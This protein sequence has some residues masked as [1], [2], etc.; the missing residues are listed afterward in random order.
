M[1]ILESGISTFFR[2][3]LGRAVERQEEIAPRLSPTWLKI[4]SG[5]MRGYLSS[6]TEE[7]LLPEGAFPLEESVCSAS[8]G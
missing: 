7:D 5:Y 3:D 2:K 8:M 1:C 4:L 6:V